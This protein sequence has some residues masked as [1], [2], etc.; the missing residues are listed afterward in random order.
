VLE[1]GTGPAAGAPARAAA[2][3]GTARL[4]PELEAPVDWERRG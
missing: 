1:S 3:A 2:G 4:V